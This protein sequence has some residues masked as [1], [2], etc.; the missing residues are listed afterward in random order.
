MILTLLVGPFL[1][2][3]ISYVVVSPTCKTC[4]LKRPF[5]GRTIF[6][7]LHTTWIWAPS[8]SRFPFGVQDAIAAGVE[9]TPNS[10]GF[11]C[12]SGNCTFSEQYSTLSF[13]HYCEDLSNEVRF[14]QTCREYN[15]TCSE[16]A[17]N[18]MS[19]LPDGFSITSSAYSAIPDIYYTT[20]QTPLMPMGFNGSGSENW[21]EF[22]IA[23]TVRRGCDSSATNKLWTCQG[24][25]ASRCMLGPCVRPYEAT[26]I[27]NV[28]AEQ[29][30]E[31]PDPF[32]S[33]NGSDNYAFIPG[34]TKTETRSRAFSTCIA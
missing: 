22:L 11:D 27:N 17:V 19:H 15:D 6:L 28:I 32:L 12:Y 18:I 4:P 1:Q 2:Q 24:Y 8:P 20:V 16:G 7:H 26:I 13:C 5:R 10:V 29:L 23:K 25:G 33:W 9:G 3:L 31:Y 34:D 21:V 14:N 30:V